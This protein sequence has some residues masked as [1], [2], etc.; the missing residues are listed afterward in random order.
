[1]QRNQFDRGA[2]NLNFFNQTPAIPTA[3]I[4]NL[5]FSDFCDN[6]GVKLLWEIN[7]DIG[8]NF[9]ILTY[10]RIGAACTHFTQSLARNRITD[11]SCI[12][13]S[14]F[15]G[16]F[17]KGAQPISRILSR[18]SLLKCE[19][20]QRKHIRSYFR[21][22][23]IPTPEVPGLKKLYGSWGLNFVQNNFR[24]FILKFLGNILGIGVRIAH[25]V[26]GATRNCIFCLNR[27]PP[28]ITDETF[29]HLFFDCPVSGSW[30]T[31]FKNLFYPELNLTNR[32]EKLAFWFG[33][34]T[35]AGCPD[36]N[37][38][39]HISLWAMKFILWEAKLKKKSPSFV[40]IKIDLIYILQNAVRVSK[41]MEFESKNGNFYISRNWA[42]L[43]RDRE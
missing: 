42:R 22:V 18:S 13:L 38:F 43:V 11:G 25:F 4:A 28:I 32:V 33:H 34:S 31:S 23:G 2:L 15:L 14:A 37:I 41:Q 8:H 39:E 20:E 29:L 3:V 35:P 40:T 36:L 19:F 9:N 21:L 17:K 16:G 1:M 6:N 5:K 10:M 24:E 27:A 7:R 12:R 26:Q 30:L